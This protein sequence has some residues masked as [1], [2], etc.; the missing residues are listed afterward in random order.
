MARITWKD[1]KYGGRDGYVGRHQFFSIA[2]KTRRDDP[3]YTLTSTLDGYRRLA[4]KND[5]A[6][7]LKGEAEKVFEAF[8]AELGAVFPPTE[9]D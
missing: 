8:V 5:D 3:N 4:E 7:V 1:S 6:N 2:W 9:R